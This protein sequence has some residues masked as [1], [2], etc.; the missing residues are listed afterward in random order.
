MPSR[1][2]SIAGAPCWIDLMTSDPDR[3]R[4][5]Y[6]E[7]FGWTSEQAGDEFGGYITFLKDGAR[8]AGA[9]AND[10]QSGAVDGWTVYLEV[11][12]AKAVADAA[13]ANGGQS[14]L[15]PMDVGDLGVM[16]LVADPGGAVVG[17][18]QPGTHKGFAVVTEPGAPS[19]FEL[20]TRDYDAS[21]EFYRKVF[22]WDA[23]VASDEPGFRYTTLGQ[24]D[25]QAAGVMDASAFLADGCAS[26]W[27]IYFGSEDTDAT[28]AKVVELG[29][30]VVQPPEDTPYGRLADVADPLGVHFKL[31]TGNV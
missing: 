3:S 24:G 28:V 20:H 13:V 7:L 2:S 29:G 21:V 12:D 11:D 4:A 27:S 25:R 1:D 23:H 17:T 10:G 8:I 14:Y 16:G 19:W 30:S 22:G 6:G 15:D 18:W 9:M 5:F 26:H 31:I